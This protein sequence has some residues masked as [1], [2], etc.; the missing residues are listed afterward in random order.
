MTRSIDAMPLE[1]AILG[2]RA[3]RAYTLET[4]DQ[5][6]LRSLLEAA[7]WAPTAMHHEPWQFIILQDR[8]LLKHLSDRAK[9]LFS[10]EAKD[11]H[12]NHGSLDLF[13]QPDFNVFYDAGTLVVVC[14][15]SASSFVFADC[16][17]A[18]ENLMLSAH[19]KGLGTCVI[20]LA[21]SA[22]NMPDVKQE[23][24]IPSETIAVAPIIVGKPRGDVPPSSRHEPQIIVW[25]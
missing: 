16:W 4:I 22:L 8:N 19:A 3:V 21:V 18:A 7:V 14:A 12:Q 2:R 23:L 1:E 15:K 6:T 11:L 24:G 10:A 9:S 17:L 20:G 5:P 25:V 13:S